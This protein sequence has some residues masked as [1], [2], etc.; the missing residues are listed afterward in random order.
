MKRLDQIAKRVEPQFYL[1]GA[2]ES[3]YAKVK[4][5]G[6]PPDDSTTSVMFASL[7]LAENVPWLLDRVRE[8]ATLVREAEWAGTAAYG[9]E[10]ACLRCWNRPDRGHDPLCGLAAALKHLDE[11][12]SK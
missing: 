10:S 11:E 8:L 5:E 12:E 7:Y 1:D 6:T 4:R 9:D 2:R 3:L